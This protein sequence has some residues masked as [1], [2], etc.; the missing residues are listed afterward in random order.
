MSSEVIVK[1]TNG[2]AKQIIELVGGS[3]NI[4]FVTCCATRLR[5]T[6]KDRGLV[7]AAAIEKLDGISGTAWAGDQFQAIV[8]LGVNELCDEVKLILGDV[9]LTEQDDSAKKGGALDTFISTI[10]SIFSPLLPALAGSGLIRGIAILLS[11]VG[12]LPEESMTYQFIYMMT[13]AIFY[14]LPFAVAFTTAQRFKTNPVTA[15]VVVGLGLLPD[16]TALV[17]GTGGNA[18]DI[19]GLPIPVFSY[20]STAFGPILTVWVQ[21]VIDHWLQKHMP[22]AFELCFTPTILIFVSA[23]LSI[24]AIG[25]AC[26]YVSIGLSEVVRQLTSMNMVITGI[27]LGGLWNVLMIFG[28][29]WAPNTL[30]IIPE[31][32]TTGSSNLIVFA[33]AAVYSCAGVALA[34][35]VRSKDKDLRA[36]SASS[37]VSIL[38]SGICEPA[39]YGVC[40]KFKSTL[41]AACIGGAVGGAFM[42]AMGCVGY[43]F[44]FPGITTLPAF[45][46]ATP[47]AWPVS[48]VISMA[49]GFVASVVIGSKDPKFGFKGLVGAKGD[50]EKSEDVAA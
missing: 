12:V 10:V 39:L 25:P 46:G 37:I 42:G 23:I 40:V 47:W 27:I 9:A 24:F 1:D 2:A 26:A 11:S 18:V 35:L 14:F 32:A 13:N 19:F 3:D 15:M 16:F 50:A 20:T 44:I 17:E 48:L 34:A 33:G 8:G 5:L 31:I 28:I 45:G 21:S 7:D 30:V 22:K 4:T 43:S 38:L 29:H 36:F 41:V 49:A 6:V